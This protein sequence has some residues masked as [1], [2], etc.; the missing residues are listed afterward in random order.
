MR[1]WLGTWNCEMQYPSRQQFITWLNHGSA[2]N[3]DI[4]A[5]GLQESDRN[6]TITIN[7]FTKLTEITVKGRTKAKSNR[8]VLMVFYRNNLGVQQHNIDQRRVNLPTWKKKLKFW[9]EYGNG[10]AVAIVDFTPNLLVPAT[11]WRIAICSAHLDSKDALSRQNQILEILNCATNSCGGGRTWDLGFF[12]GDLNYRLTQ[13]GVIGVGTTKAQLVT[14]FQ[15][16]LA[17]LFAQDGLNNSGDFAN[18]TFPDPCNGAPGQPLYLPTYKR[19][20]KGAEGIT[21]A[22]QAGNLPNG[23]SV[24]DCFHIPVE[25]HTNVVKLGERAGQYDLGWLDRIGYRNRSM[26]VNLNVA[27][28]RSGSLGTHADGVLSDHTPVY[29]VFDVT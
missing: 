12:M 29:S 15:T 4:I 24:E 22:G 20:Y 2:G 7:G 19:L 21:A 14:R 18:W 17:G 23:T 11:F 16:N 9:A 26:G 5:I 28:V 27:H 1:I 8:Q 3:A 13:G 25:K 6:G 10:G